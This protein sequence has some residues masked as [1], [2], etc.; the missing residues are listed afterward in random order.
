MDILS[1][2]HKGL[3][4]L[5]A[6]ARARNVKGIPAAFAD[7]LHRQLTFIQAA[8]NIQQLA[9]VPSWRL[10]LLEPKNQQRWSMWVSGNYRLTFRLN[11][12]SNEVLDVD[13]EDYH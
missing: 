3:K 5:A 7:K 6:S 12:A 10:H 11:P 9:T 8:S 4:A 1:Y 2:R 13:L